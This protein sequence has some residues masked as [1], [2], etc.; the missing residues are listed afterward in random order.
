LRAYTERKK[1]RK[2]T[3]KQGNEKR[4]D[5]VLVIPNLFDF[6]VYLAIL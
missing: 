6:F 4:I 2:K 5:D 3:A 1:E